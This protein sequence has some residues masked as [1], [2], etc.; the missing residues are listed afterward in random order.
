M[1][2]RT[3][4]ETRRRG[5]LWNVASEPPNFAPSWPERDGSRG[6]GFFSANIL[7]FAVRRPLQALI[8]SDLAI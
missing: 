2:E 4:H 8:G 1:P 3:V 7:F 5:G 6:G